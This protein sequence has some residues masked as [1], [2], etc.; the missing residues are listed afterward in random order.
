MINI[1]SRCWAVF[2]L[3]VSILTGRNIGAIKNAIVCRF[4]HIPSSAVPTSSNRAKPATV[5]LPN[6]QRG[7][8]G[9]K[10]GAIAPFGF[11]N[12]PIA[13]WTLNAT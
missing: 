6:L 3:S 12:Q 1:S 9:L 13:Q 11:Q 10:I 4:Q 2:G 5:N 7:W 8:N